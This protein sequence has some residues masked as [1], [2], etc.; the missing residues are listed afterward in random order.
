MR[1]K[2]GK[3]QTVRLLR[4]K[5][6][7]DDKWVSSRSELKEFLVVKYNNSQECYLPVWNLVGGNRVKWWG[8]ETHSLLKKSIEGYDSRWERKKKDSCKLIKARELFN[9]KLV[10]FHSD[11]FDEAQEKYIFWCKEEGEEVFPLKIGKP[12][13]DD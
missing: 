8:P 11:D 13:G 12:S 10:C 4:T 2:M 5:P 3:E 1:Q 7:I 6:F 9:N